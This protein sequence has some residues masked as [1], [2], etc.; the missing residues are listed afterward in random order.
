[1]N[2]RET[3]FS[4]RRKSHLGA[5]AIAATVAVVALGGVLSPVVTSRTQAAGAAAAINAE[6]LDTLLAQL[7]KQ[8]EQLVSNQTKVE[9]Q[10]GL[11]K[12][13]LRL[14]RIYSGRSGGAPRR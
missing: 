2:S 5:L 1:M 11:L 14:T 13:E 7:K 10:I 3:F 6:T 8:Q 4:L 9:T 12:E